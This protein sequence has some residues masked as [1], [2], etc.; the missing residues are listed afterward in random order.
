MKIFSKNQK[1]LKFLEWSKNQINS[2]N[3]IF[4][5]LKEIQIAKN[6]EIVQP[7]NMIVQQMK[8]NGSIK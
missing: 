3:S 6:Q 5:K 8:N 4:D 1:D 2:P 7:N